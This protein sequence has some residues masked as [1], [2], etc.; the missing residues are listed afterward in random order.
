MLVSMIPLYIIL[1][2]PGYGGPHAGFFAVKRELIKLIPGRIVGQTR[3]VQ[4]KY[5][6]F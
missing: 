3:Y 6:Y 1:L 5:P 2:F 4:N